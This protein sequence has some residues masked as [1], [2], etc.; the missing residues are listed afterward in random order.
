MTAE[1]PFAVG[2]R[3]AEHPTY[4]AWMAE[5]VVTV[6]GISARSDDLTALDLIFKFEDANAP[7]RHRGPLPTRLDP[8]RP[9]FRFSYGVNAILYAVSCDIPGVTVSLRRGGK[10][11]P[12][13]SYTHDYALSGHPL[14][15]YW[16]RHSIDHYLDVLD[17][18]L[19]ATAPADVT[20]HVLATSRAGLGDD[21]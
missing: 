5:G 6:D 9:A 12:C 3:L 11:T 1:S 4:R 17:H 2:R 14:R 10:N 15:A 21:R 20:L 13:F 7:L 16:I 19:D 18:H 8:D